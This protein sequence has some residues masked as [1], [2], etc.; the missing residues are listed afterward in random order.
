MQLVPLRQGASGLG[1]Q[2]RRRHTQAESAG[3]VD[4]VAEE[5]ADAGE[6]R[7]EPAPAP[8]WGL[9]KLN[10]LHSYWILYIV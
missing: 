2:Q 3:A 8:R 5:R 10:A 4:A 7:R 9:Y 1:V 6:A